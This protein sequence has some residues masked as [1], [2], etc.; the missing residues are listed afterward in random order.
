MA[1]ISLTI[2]D[3]VIQR[4]LDALGGTYGYKA[5]LE[6]GTPNPQ[7]KAQFSKAVVADYVK[8]IVRQWEAQQAGQT[9]YNTAAN[10]VDINVTIS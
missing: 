7:T 3:A 8:K 2:P 1:T 10:D 4:V 9:A 6:D 5:T